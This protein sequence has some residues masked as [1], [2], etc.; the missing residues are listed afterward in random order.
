MRVEVHDGEGWWSLAGRLISEQRG[1]ARARDNVTV[2]L[3]AEALERAAQGALPPPGGTLALPPALV[4][5]LV[6]RAESLAQ[7]GCS[8]AQ[9][10]AALAGPRPRAREQLAAG[11]SRGPVVY[12]PQLDESRGS[13]ARDVAD[14]LLREHAPHACELARASLTAQVQYWLFS[15]GAEVEPNVP[16]SLP[17]LPVERLLSSLPR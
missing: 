2:G 10:A 14:A 8:P 17:G 3:V 11:L 5:G 1:A 12:L 6:D 4:T 9:I 16:L 7:H 15:S 13:I